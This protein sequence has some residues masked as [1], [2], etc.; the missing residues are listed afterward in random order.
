MTSTLTSHFL[1]FLLCR[2][3][4]QGQGKAAMEYLARVYAKKLAPEQIC[5][6]TVTPGIYVGV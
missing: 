3:D 2:Y 1:T 5:V 4:L 6:N